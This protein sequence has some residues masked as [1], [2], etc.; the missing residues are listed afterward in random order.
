MGLAEAKKKDKGEPLKPESRWY[1][2]SGGVRARA[3]TEP[4]GVLGHR[5]WANETAQ[6]KVQ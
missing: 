5:E 4:P 3:V 6:S 2:N 1:G